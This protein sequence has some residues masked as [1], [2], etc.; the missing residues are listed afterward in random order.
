[1]ATDD[2]KPEAH[3]PAGAGGESPDQRSPRSVGFSDRE[4]ERVERAAAD[5]SLPPAAFVRNAALTAASSGATPT[6]SLP[7]GITE[8]IKRTF[9]GTYLLT[10]LKRDEMV[11]DGRRDDLERV[12]RTARA[13]HDM[14]LGDDPRGA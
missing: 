3:A 10:T 13:T 14:L 4:W 8:L 6:G 1:M 2:D 9:L 5:S 7:P 12:L 11:L